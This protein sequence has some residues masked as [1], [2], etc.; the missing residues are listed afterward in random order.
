MDI[1]RIESPA[2]I[3]LRPRSLWVE[4]VRMAVKGNGEVLKRISPLVVNP[5]FNRYGD[6]QTEP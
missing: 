4:L 3:R 1:A 6:R 2:F 5:G